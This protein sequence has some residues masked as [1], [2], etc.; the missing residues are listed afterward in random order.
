MIDLSK[1][2]KKGL[3]KTVALANGAQFMKDVGKKY[4]VI[5]L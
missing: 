4:T 2:F 3:R 1:Y 5:L